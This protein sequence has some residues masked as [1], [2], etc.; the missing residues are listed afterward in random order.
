MLSAVLPRPTHS[1]LSAASISFQVSGSLFL[2]Q[3]V[4]ISSRQ[5]PASWFI[6]SMYAISST[7]TPIYQTVCTK[8]LLG[9]GIYAKSFSSNSVLGEA[10]L[11]DPVAIL[12]SLLV[13]DHAQFIKLTTNP[14][15]VYQRHNVT[16]SKWVELYQLLPQHSR[17]LF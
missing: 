13:N 4:R 12:L 5:S 14:Q 9:R 10:G 3:A 1:S 17:N 2:K 11:L 15:N 8:F 7:L 16:L 6:F